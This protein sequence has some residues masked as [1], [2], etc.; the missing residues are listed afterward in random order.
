MF[1]LVSFLFH[2]VCWLHPGEIEHIANGMG[3]RQIITRRS[4][5]IPM[6]PVGGIPWQI[7]SMNSSS[8]GLASSSPAS[9]RLTSL[10]KETCAEAQDHSV[11]YRHCRF[12]WPR[13]KLS[14]RSTIP[15][16]VSLRDCGAVCKEALS[17]SD[18]R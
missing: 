12:R 13:I 1:P 16:C 9:R 10:F 14:N 11:R 2:A 8:R 15:S 18:G 7:A 5:P 4:M 3:I 6:P 17:R